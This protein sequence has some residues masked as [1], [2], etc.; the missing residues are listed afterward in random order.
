MAKIYAKTLAY[1]QNGDH[2]REKE[3][4]HVLNNAGG[5]SGPGPHGSLKTNM[6]DTED[7]H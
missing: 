2:E 4:A 3:R 6:A 1:Q 7:I 5:L